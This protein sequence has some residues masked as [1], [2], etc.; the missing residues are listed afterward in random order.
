[1][2]ASLEKSEKSVR[3]YELEKETEKRKLDS[4]KRKYEETIEKMNNRIKS[5]EKNEEENERLLK[6]IKN[7][8]IVNQEIK[9]EN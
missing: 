6:S 1:M 8:E 3:F 9:E 5:M 2:E 7:L 4:V